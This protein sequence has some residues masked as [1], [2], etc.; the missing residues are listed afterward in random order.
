MNAKFGAAGNGDLF[1]AEG[2]KASED[3]PKW[4][5]NFGLDAYE[6]FEGIIYGIRQIQRSA[7]AG[8]GDFGKFLFNCFDHCLSAVSCYIKM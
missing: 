4:L 1:Y 6:L 5:K 3:M 7:A 2:F 8:F